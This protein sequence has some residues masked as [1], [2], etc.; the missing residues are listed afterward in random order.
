MYFSHYLAN[1]FLT[2]MSNCFT[3][4]N[5]TDM[6]CCYKVFRSDLIK[7]LDLRE[8]RFGIEPEIIAKLAHQRPRIYEMAVS[9]HGR[10]YEEGKKIGWKDA[11]RAVYCILHY[12]LPYCR[13]FVQ[14]LFYICVGGI[15]AVVNLLV[16]LSLYSLGAGVIV[17]APAV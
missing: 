1:R 10:T 16:F 6:E 5:L 8:K 12:N 14:F 3:G 11:F 4:L 9:Y 15:A 2:F 17:S 7:K 13:G